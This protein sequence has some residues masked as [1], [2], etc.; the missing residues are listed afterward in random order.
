MDKVKFGNLLYELRKEKNLTQ[1]EFAEMFNVSFQAVSKWEK[2]D[3]I[4]DIASLESISVFYG[5]SINDLLNGVGKNQSNDL[6][7]RVSKDQSSIGNEKEKGNC[8][9]LVK[10]RLFKLL[11][12]SIMF[13]VYLL[14]CFIPAINVSVLQYSVDTNYYDLLFT[15]NYKE[16]NMLIL[17][18]FLSMVSSFILGIIS[19]FVKDNRIIVGVEG[20]FI[21]VGVLFNLAVNLIFRNCA[22]F[23]LY[24]M[25]TIE[26]A[27][28]CVF[29]AL[30]QLNFNTLFLNKK[31]K[32]FDEIGIYFLIFSLILIYSPDEFSNGM[33]FREYILMI[34]DIM[35]VPSVLLFGLS[36]KNN[37]TIRILSYN[38]LGIVLVCIFI[39][40]LCTNFEMFIFSIVLGVLY[41]TFELV[42]NKNL[43]KYEAN[44]IQL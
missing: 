36:F 4:P 18:S 27:Y 30:P 33:Y 34:G 3:S 11:V 20:P 9:L 25:T 38:A 28:C 21:I 32:Y 5:I 24:F 13:G 14:I 42:T 19:V 7:N 8:S 2:G 10:K 26:I 17:I 6:E 31:Q 39:C 43:K 29:L 44:N 22:I 23:G 37:K 35:F 1:Q 16:G 40:G 41:L 12:C 15:S